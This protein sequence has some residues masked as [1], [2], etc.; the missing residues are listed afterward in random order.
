MYI[1]RS[2]SWVRLEDG[3]ILVVDGETFTRDSRVTSAISRHRH[4]W[5]LRHVPTS[6]L[7]FKTLLC[8]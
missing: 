7:T 5:S 3:H 6:A 4:T 2:V 1:A 8:Q